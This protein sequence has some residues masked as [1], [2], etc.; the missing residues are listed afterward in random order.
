M[1]SASAR[2]RRRPVCELTSAD[3]G[4][5]DV[6]EHERL[7][8]QTPGE[9]DGGR[10]LARINKDVVGEPEFG[11]L[12]DAANEI[13]ACEELIVG[14]GLRDVSKSAELW[15]SRKLF[16][17]LAKIGRA[18]IHPADHAFDEI[19]PRRQIEQELRFALGL[20]GLHCDGSVDVIRS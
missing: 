13:F 4:L 2:I 8:R 19:V 12:R 14:F 20:I 18:E 3:I 1:R 16:Q 7:I 15:E 6:I 11:E 17:T 10:K 5:G 9:F